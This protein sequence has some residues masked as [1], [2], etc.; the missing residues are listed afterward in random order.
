MSVSAMTSVLV[1]C[2]I[3][4]ISSNWGAL[5]FKLNAQAHSNA[6]VS[7]RRDFLGKA[8]TGAAA[9]AL[10]AMPQV[11]RGEAGLEDLAAPTAEEAAK[12][13]EEER[14]R[15]KLKA[16]QEATDRGSGR[17]SF[18]DSLEQEK[19]KQAAM[20]KSKEQRRRDLCEELGRGC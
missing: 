19:A 20:K 18:S 3:L 8:F 4:C 6:A 2:V 9:V 15:R 1:L 13:D 11:A 5:A 12:A 7:T 17:K 10:V 14:V 16:Q